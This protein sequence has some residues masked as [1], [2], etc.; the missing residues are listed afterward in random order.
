VIRSRAAALVLAACAT[1]CA[2]EKAGAPAPVVTAAPEPSTVE[3][4][5]AQ[6]ARAH[7]QL[8]GAPSD[9]LHADTSGGPGTGGAAD[10]ATPRSSE[11][12]FAGDTRKS[13]CA[14]VCNAIA[15][16]KRAVDAICRMAG[17]A[18]PR[19]LEARKTLADDDAKV[20]RCTCR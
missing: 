1:G 9:A 16:M 15:S 14:V 3:E 4:A 12:P 13:P 5:Q 6:L 20:A 8:G 10:E 18:D 19:C 11:Q 17:E 7:E 2:A